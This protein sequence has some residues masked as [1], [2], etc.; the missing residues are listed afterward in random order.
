MRNNLREY[1]TAVGLCTPTIGR[2]EYQP[3]LD[4]ITNVG[5]CSTSAPRTEGK[6]SEQFNFFGRNL[7]EEEFNSAKEISSEVYHDQLGM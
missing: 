4:D 2:K 6:G 3:P 7:Y 5:S 1:I